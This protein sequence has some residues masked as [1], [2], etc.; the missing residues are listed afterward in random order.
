MC[1]ARFIS[2]RV[3]HKTGVVASKVTE[4]DD[5]EDGIVQYDGFHVQV[6]SGFFHIVDENEDGTL[7]FSPEIATF[8][9]AAAGVIWKLK[10]SNLV[11]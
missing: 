8:A 5:L 4:P 1:D 9:L 7:T 3:E 11:V 6:G 2:G 10:K